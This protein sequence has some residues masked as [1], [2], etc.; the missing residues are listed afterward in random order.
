MY[1]LREFDIINQGSGMEQQAFIQHFM[2]N[3]E[4]V[5]SYVLFTTSRQVAF[6]YETVFM[7]ITFTQIQQHSCTHPMLIQTK[8]CFHFKTIAKLF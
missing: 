8:K 4:K 6:D 1:Q 3:T 5:S 2:I 7:I